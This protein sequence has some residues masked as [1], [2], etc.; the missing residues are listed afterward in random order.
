[1]KTTP[2]VVAALVVVGIVGYF[3]YTANLT[4]STPT[5]TKT[6]SKTYRVN[7]NTNVN[8]AYHPVIVPSNYVA[9]VDN[10]F[11]PLPVGRTYV[12]EGQEKGG[13]VKNTVVVTSQT[14]TILG[15]TTAV[16]HDTVNIDGKLEEE[17]Y[18]WYA[19]D[20]TGNVWYFGEDAK[21]YENGK[22]TGTKGSWEAGVNGAEP[23]MIM[24]ASPRVGD[25]YRQEYLR[26][27]AEDMSAI[28]AINESVTVPSGSYTNC[29]KTKDWTALEPTVIENKLF[30]RGAG[31][32]QSTMIQGG[33]D[34][35][36]LASI[37]D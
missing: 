28:L 19:Q 17:T 37:T 15:V 18:D 13:T 3:L 31:Q 36:K 26:G 32:V 22:V 10:A 9:K 30:C 35:T 11:F 23:G 1:M 16:V 33:Q 21:T 7:S 29:I 5:G 20:K 25:Q 14:K 4:Q 6:T 34:V 8:A 24:E 12:S 2:I 27:Q